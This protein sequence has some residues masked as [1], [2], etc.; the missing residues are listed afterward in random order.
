MSAITAPVSPRAS[1][2]TSD[3]IA[4]CSAEFALK[5]LASRALTA[6]NTMIAAA[7]ARR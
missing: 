7:M 2:L 5:I 3:V 6:R 1:S 4:D